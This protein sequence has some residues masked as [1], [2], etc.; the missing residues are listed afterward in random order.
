MYKNILLAVD[1]SEHALRATKEAV[2]LAS[3]IKDCVI[4]MVLV[5]DFSQTYRRVF[6][7]H[8]PHP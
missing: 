1:G 7:Q 4:E 5:A 3:L 2:K 6:T 8:P